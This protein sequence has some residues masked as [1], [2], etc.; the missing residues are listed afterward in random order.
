MKSEGVGSWRDV[1]QIVLEREVPK[2]RGQVPTFNK[3]K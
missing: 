1:A 3:I 2:G